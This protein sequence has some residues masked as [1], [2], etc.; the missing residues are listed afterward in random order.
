LAEIGVERTDFVNI[1]TQDLE[2]AK[3]FYGETLGLPRN[4]RSSDSWPEYET[5]N[6][7]LL[8]A[9]AAR[10][11]VPFSPSNNAVALRV[12]DVDAAK[13]RLEEAGVEFEFEETYDTGVCHMAFFRDPDGN[14]LILHHRY[15]PYS[16][17]TTP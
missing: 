13:G 6:L 9:D 11:S 14:A 1:A 2:R 15:A 4:P 12:A 8:L 16:D 10:T 5:G 3:R 17:G 7:T